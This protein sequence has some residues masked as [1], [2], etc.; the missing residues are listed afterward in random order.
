MQKSTSTSNDPGSKHQ[1]D[2]DTLAHDGGIMQ[3][4]ADGHI[5]IIGHRGEQEIVQIGK[6]YEK[7]HLCYASCIGDGLILNLHIYQHFRD[8]D[9]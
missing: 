9:R 1:L 6:K 5:P 2:T 8:G 3:R 7:I 4:V